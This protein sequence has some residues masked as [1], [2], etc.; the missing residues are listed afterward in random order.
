MPKATI[1]SSQFA[2][3]PVEKFEDFELQ[4]LS[5]IKAGKEQGADLL[6][7][8]EYFSI[9][10]IGLLDDTRDEAKLFRELATY[11][12]RIVEFCVAQ[13]KT[14]SLYI[15]AGSLPT[16][17][18][19]GKNTLYNEAFIC[20]PDGQFMSQGKLNLTSWEKDN[21][22]MSPLSGLRVFDTELAGC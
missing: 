4:L 20:S 22:N 7:L 2:L 9:N 8:P 12:Q 6:L 16:L 3:K 10:L 19:T 17:G 5:S 14:Y 1:A 18:N 15:V 13:A 21:L 11:S